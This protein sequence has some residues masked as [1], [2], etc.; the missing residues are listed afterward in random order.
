MVRGDVYA[1]RLRAQHAKLNPRAAWAK[2]KQKDH[3]P[4]Q[5]A[6]GKLL[7]QQGGLLGDGGLLAPGELETSRLRDANAAD[8]AEA[9]VRCLEYHPN[10]QLLLTAGLDKRLRFF[11]VD[12]DTN[13]LVQSLFLED[14][15]VHTAAFALGGT[16]VLATG[17]RRHFY[18][19]DLE[20]ASL[21]RVPCL[22]GVEDK[23]LESFVANNA[24][25]GDV[26]AFFGRDGTL[27][28]MS[29]RS[30][31]IVGTLKM[32]GTA[33]SGAFSSDGRELYTAG[34]DGIVYVWD[35]RQ[36]TC[37]ARFVDE[38]ALRGTALAVTQDGGLLAT[39]MDGCCLNMR[40]AILLL[41]LAAFVEHSFSGSNVH[42][43]FINTQHPQGRAVALSTFMVGH[44]SSMAQ[45]DPQPRASLRPQQQRWCPSRCTQRST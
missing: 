22:F 21:E 44:R 9:V 24:E 17:R 40:T 20:A 32:N 28:L 31:Q 35:V 13:P 16:K 14:L 42:L 34:G 6:T 15:P 1:E 2:K 18:V 26:V 30:R 4:D 8:A 43:Y 23:S 29:M 41:A 45:L 7:T 25:G 33:R 36:R 5:S 27:P 11:A 10:G 37:R 38:G 39:G 19:A 12:G 3:A